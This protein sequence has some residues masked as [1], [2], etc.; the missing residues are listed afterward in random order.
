MT[1]NP[2]SVSVLVAILG[3]YSQ[4]S[5]LV[6]RFAHD[7][8]K[9][10]YRPGAIEWIFLV[11]GEAWHRTLPLASLAASDVRIKVVRCT[12]ELPAVL[13]N[14]GAS[15]AAGEFV[16]FAWPGIDFGACLLNARRF[17]E[18]LSSQPGTEFQAGSTAPGLGHCDRVRSWTLGDP[19]GVPQGYQGGWLEMFDAVPMEC[20]FVSRRLF[21]SQGGFSCCPLLQR[22]F[23]WEFTIRVS[24]TIQL[25][26][27]NVT[28]PPRRWSWWD[29]PL[30]SDLPTSG[31]LI[32]RRALRRR[33]TPKAVGVTA[34]YSDLGSFARD[35]AASTRRRLRLLLEQWM[36][37]K[38]AC[39]I[40]L[41]STPHVSSGTDPHAPLRIV[42]LG[43]LNEPAHNQ[44]CF[45]NYF[46]LLE[47]QGVLTWRCILDSAAHNAD[48]DKAD[49]VIFSR[50]RTESACRL[51]DYCEEHKIP[52]VYMLDDNW[53]A[54]GKEW[55]EYA[56]IFRPGA[57]P[58]EHFMYCLARANQVLTYNELLADDLRPYNSCL[59]VLP[60]NIDL[61]LFNRA[62]RQTQDRPRV[63]YAGSLRR[64]ESAFKALLELAQ[65]RDDFD[66]FVMS[67]SIPEPLKS[68]PGDR[69]VYRPYVF[70][71]R[72]YAQLLCEA[73]PD[74]L[75]GPLSKTRTDASKCPNKYLEITAA[76]AAGVYSKTAPYDRFIRDH[77]N[78]LLVEND[79]ANWKS[80]IAELLDDPHLRRNI[81]D[82]AYRDVET[83]FSTSAVLPE[84]MALLKRTA[85]MGPD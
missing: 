3:D 8:L 13:F 52:T 29:F 78:G 82:A 80:A 19:D 69:L 68:L 43:G 60:T 59:D 26:L 15:V 64:E 41:D 56:N 70:G 81:V 22:G 38:A 10:D 28:S 48:L 7:V 49:L 85:G 54:V 11:H 79:K 37:D 17:A 77:D 16:G 40:P 47:G 21:L 5:R 50:C 25:D 74:V 76:G 45:Y 72:R 20:A 53:F 30:N 62:D 83:N 4:V 46:A 67:A 34:D 14:Q 33:E 24:R 61:T 32:A 12:E 35:L 9:S 51:M 23:W 1:S 66:V 65:E 57:P 58:Y 63:G 18:S 44:L 73:R 71:Y 75:L 39:P 2:P 84:F 55:P 42:V 6:D 36:P 27:L 31:D